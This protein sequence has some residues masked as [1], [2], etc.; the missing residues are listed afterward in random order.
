MTYFL[1]QDGSLYA[2][3]END[4]SRLMTKSLNPG[5]K[6]SKP[7]LCELLKG[8]RISY[9]SAGVSHVIVASGMDQVH[10]FLVLLNFILVILL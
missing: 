10:P 4:N 1:A 6:A 5:D 3:G 9:V 2:C 8:R 7:I